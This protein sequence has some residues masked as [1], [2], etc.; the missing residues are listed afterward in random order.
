MLDLNPQFLKAFELIENTDKNIFVTGRA[1]TGKSTLLS[2][3]RENTDK[4]MAVLAP[5][6]V[7]ALNVAGQTIHSFFGFKPNVTY[8][9]VRKLPRKKAEQ[10]AIYK[11]LETI[12]IDEVSMVRADLLDCVDK[13]MRLN[14]KTAGQPFGG[15]QM[16]FFGDLYQLPPVVT[17]AERRIFKENYKSAFFFDA[18]LFETGTDADPKLFETGFEMELVEL[19]KIYRQRDINL[20]NILNAIRNNTVTESDLE[21]LNSQ[22][23][24]DFEPA[25]DDLYIYLTTTNA[26]AADVNEARLKKIKGKPFFI[27]GEITGEFEKKSLPTTVSLALKIGAQVMLLNND[28]AGRW[29]NGTVGKIAAI[30]KKEGETQVDVELLD[31]KTVTVTPFTWKLFNFTFDDASQTII[32]QEVGSFEQMP[33]KLAWAITVHKSQG[34]TFE[35]VVFDIGRGT[36]AHG[37]TYVALSRCTD[38]GGL[39]LKKP[40]RKSDIILDFDV[41][42]FLTRHQYR[43]AEKKWPLEEKIRVL[44]E[45]ASKKEAVEITYLKA[46][47]VK[48][49]RMIVPSLVEEMEYKG[50]SFLGV[51]A[52]CQLHQ[53]ERVFRVDRI[54]EIKEANQNVKN[55]DLLPL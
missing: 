52:F 22:C 26:L 21:I 4:K 38:L 8:D 40:L 55:H 23:D 28:S 53:A 37:Q 54:L 47:D 34:K 50:K 13:F 35:K 19:E 41:V 39:V 42:N 43:M 32:S 6:G 27:D 17:S 46:R 29:I 2:Y 24:P 12:V 3:V 7:A 15:V 44:K 14:G 5:T 36:F 9:K 10:A 18:K 45:A 49:R 31:G 16:V 1:G 51:K 30:S 25:I 11:K 48:S 20:I 33:I